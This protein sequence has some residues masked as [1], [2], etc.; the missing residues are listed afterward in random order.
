VHL[1]DCAIHFRSDGLA[2]SPA[3]YA[4]VLTRLTQQDHIAADEFS[5]GGAVERLEQRMAE[6][7]GKEMA[8]FMPSGTLANHLAVRLLAQRGRRVLVQRESHLYCDCGDCAQELSGLTLVPLAPARTSFTLDEAMAEAAHE[9]AGR[10]RAPIGAISIESPVRRRQGEVFDFA[11]MRRIVGFARE[12]GIGLHLDG[13]RLFL[14]A[15]YTGVAAAAYAA[16]FDTV[17]VSL[18][19]YFN[20][21]GGAVLAGPRRLLD[22]LHH[23]RRAFG[24]GLRQAWPYAAVALHY[25][26]GFAERFAEAAAM[27][28]QLFLALAEHPGVEALRSPLSTNVTR[29]RVHGADAAALPERLAARG[30]SIRPP[31]AGSGKTAEFELIANESIRRRPLAQTI[32]DFSVAIGGESPPVRAG[33]RLS[34]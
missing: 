25:L 29:L 6:L 9:D 32:A 26:E 33:R 13:A 11:E 18:Y 19:K 17:Y 1:Q 2:L 7:L 27:A 4:C 14:A 30:I 28:D 10:V 34:D 31:V 16:P 20:A 8:V 22:G 3:E 23:Q 24:G 21:A 12:R 5:R 15:P